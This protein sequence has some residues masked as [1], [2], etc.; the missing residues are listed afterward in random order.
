MTPHRGRLLQVDQS[1]RVCDAVAAGAVDCA[2][3]GG[4]VP[5]ELAHSLRAEPFAQACARGPPLA[6]PAGAAWAPM[7]G[8][9]PTD[10]K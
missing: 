6:L 9:D 1:R 5:A 7:A 10:G 8:G 4:E 3:I 2:I